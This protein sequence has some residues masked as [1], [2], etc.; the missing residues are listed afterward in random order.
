MQGGIPLF[1]LIV[2]VHKELDKASDHCVRGDGRFDVLPALI[3]HCQVCWILRHLRLILHF[4]RTFKFFNCSAD[5]LSPRWFPLLCFPFWSCDCGPVVGNINALD[6]L[7]SK[8]RHVGVCMSHLAPLLP[9]PVR[10]H[11][12][13]L[14]PV[15]H[16]ILLV[17]GQ[18]W[19]MTEL[20]SPT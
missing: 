11:W 13:K 18:A 5:L 7:G 6:T 14:G 9:A 16:A 15:W 4:I 2:L 1:L 20:V 8:S 19:M 12:S 17:G 10:E 3:S